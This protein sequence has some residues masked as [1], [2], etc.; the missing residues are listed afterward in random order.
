MIKERDIFI[1]I[2]TLEIDSKIWFHSG[3]L[4]KSESE[5]FDWAGHGEY[6]PIIAK[7]GQFLFILINRLNIGK[8]FPIIL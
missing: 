4:Y 1:C 6:I 3:K 2:K 8:S 7:Y 5:I